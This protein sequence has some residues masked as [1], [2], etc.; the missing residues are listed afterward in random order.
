MSL[1]RRTGILVCLLP[2]PLLLFDKQLVSKEGK[3]T[4][5]DGADTHGVDWLTKNIT[6]GLFLSDRSVLNDV[7]TELTVVTGIMMQNLP[8][9]SAWHLR[10]LRRIGVAKE[11][12]EEVWKCVG[13]I[14]FFSLSLSYCRWGWGGI[15]R[16]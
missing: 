1:S 8:R 6:Y 2:S 3:D 4:P 11:D 14:R 15:E 13:Y 5:H 7:E 9:E 12:A 10:G 16:C